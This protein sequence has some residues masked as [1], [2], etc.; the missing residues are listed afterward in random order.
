MQCQSIR[1]KVRY[2]SRRV[3]SGARHFVEYE[4]GEKLGASVPGTIE[5]FLLERYLLFVVRRAGLYVGQVHHSPY[6]AQLADVLTVEDE[7]I[8]AAGLPQPPQP[9][10]LAHYAAGVDVEIFP[11]RR[12]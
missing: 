6:P 9:P 1:G 4:I 2:E 3:G 8:A 12:C 10:D 5:H 7:L 11:L